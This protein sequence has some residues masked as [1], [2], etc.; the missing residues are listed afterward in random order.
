[1]KKWLSYFSLSFFSDKIAKEGKKRS[2][3]N[4]ALGFILALAFLFGGVVAADIVPFNTH[5]NH[6]TD[7]QA[8]VHNAF[9]N[10]DVSKRIS[11]SINDGVAFANIGSNDTVSELL[12]DTFA[13]PDDAII[14]KVNGYELVVDTRSADA[15]DDFVAYCVSNDGKEEEITY[16]EY[17]TL[18]DVAK[19]NFDFKIRYTA[20]ELVL[21][22]ELVVQYE[23]YLAGISSEQ[24]EKIASQYKELR[25]KKATLTA[26]EYSQNVYKLYLQAY[27]PSLS[28]YE[29]GGVPLLR[30]Y[31]YDNYLSADNR[32]LVVFDDSCIASFETNNGVAV[33][34]YGFYVKMDNGLVTNGTSVSEAEQIIDNFIKNAYLG[35]S[36]TIVYIYLLNFTWLFL[37]IVAIPLVI[38]LFA[39][40]LLK[41][42]GVEW[43]KRYGYSLKVVGSYMWCAALIAALITFICGYF[44]PGLN[45]MIF[46]LGG[47]FIVLLVRTAILLINERIAL[48][49]L[50]AEQAKLEEA[51]EITTDQPPN[52]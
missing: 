20:N 2:Y 50:Q 15:Y 38:A 44:A 45:L 1:M 14:Y 4:F 27:Y 37:L 40:C 22:D 36:S 49:K 30:N 39:Y 51:Q 52:T 28:A 47:F 9:A 32:F 19:R 10:E 42:M 41:F 31:Y 17:L 46:A 21:T 11:I 24:N 5:Y 3:L 13:N 7:F 8:F 18:S 33:S 26:I 12:V 29:V 34:F 6:A 48:K 35:N 23:S 25:D 43:C 16:E